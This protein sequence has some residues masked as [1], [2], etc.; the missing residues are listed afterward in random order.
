MRQHPFPRFFV[1]LAILLFGLGCHMPAEQNRPAAFVGAYS[2]TLPCADC[3]GMQ[4]RIQLGE[5]G[6][7]VSTTVYLGKSDAPFRAE[8][9]YSQDDQGRLLLNPGMEDQQYLAV[10]GDGLWWLDREG[11]RIEG[12][13]AS[14]YRLTR[15]TNSME[16]SADAASSGSLQTPASIASAEGS[17]LYLRKWQGGI[18]FY[19]LG[20]EPFWSLDW[21]KNGGWV[22]QTAEGERIE[23]DETEPAYLADSG[24]T[25]FRFQT[26]DHRIS[27]TLEDKPCSDGMSGAAFDL[28]V[29]LTV[30]G[31]SIATPRLYRGCGSYS[32]DPRLHN[33]WALSSLD[34]EA[35][36]A[37]AYPKGV[38]TLEL[39]LATRRASGFD[40][41][42]QYGGT[43]TAGPGG[44]RFS[45]MRGTLMACSGEGVLYSL[46][47]RLSEAE[48]TYTWKADGR[49]V[50]LQEGKTWAEFRPVD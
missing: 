43:L 23:L 14:H 8:G 22:F 31:N 11:K 13:L 9:E 32:A 49:L 6:R 10:D 46:S 21:K 40:G 1:L 39:N 30:Q 24:L 35:V 29:A 42:N 45:A 27:L 15:I 44:L 25:R 48:V 12:S 5:D 26:P 3:E 38:P 4:Y 37:S 19:A 28:T 20:T 16:A 17:D 34:G 33:I 41:C 36:M 50:L 7:F 18:R 47:K 2:G